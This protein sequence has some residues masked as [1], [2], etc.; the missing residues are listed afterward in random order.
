MTAA[1]LSFLPSPHH[2][3]DSTTRLDSSSLISSLNLSLRLLRSLRTREM[4][5]NPDSFLLFFAANGAGE[6]LDDDDETGRVQ[7]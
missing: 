5:K 7:E 2:R 1:A 3:R 4:T 6:A